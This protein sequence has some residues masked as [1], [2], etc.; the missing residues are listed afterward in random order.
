MAPRLIIA[1]LTGWLLCSSAWLRAVPELAAI[2]HSV[3]TV[4]DI[5]RQ[6]QESGPRHGVR[7]ALEPV[8][9]ADRKLAE[10]TAQSGV[11]YFRYEPPY[12]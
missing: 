12:D 3:N 4:A 11:T 1:M 2:I 8:T 10:V 5:M 6:L 9:E 7:A